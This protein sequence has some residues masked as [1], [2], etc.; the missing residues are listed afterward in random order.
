MLLI[1]TPVKMAGTCQSVKESC[2]LF[3]EPQLTSFLVFYNLPHVFQIFTA[4]R[5]I[6]WY[7][8]SGKFRIDH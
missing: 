4:Y 2:N 8:L 3:T 7:H 6:C 5:S 1:P